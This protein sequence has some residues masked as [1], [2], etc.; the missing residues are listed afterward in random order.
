MENH[1]VVQA[2]YDRCLANGDFFQTFYDIFLGTS[3][4]VSAK[5][6]KTD[7]NT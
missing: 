1:E 5:F 3:P 6:A 2:S 7:F 4:E